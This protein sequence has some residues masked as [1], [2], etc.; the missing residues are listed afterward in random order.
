MKFHC[1]K[2]LLLRELT[3]AQEV[4]SN[5]S[6]ISI[7]SNVMLAVE[8][9]RLLLRATDTKTAYEAIIPVSV[10]QQGSIT[11]NSDKFIGSMK[12]LPD[13]LVSFELLPDGRFLIKPEKKS[14]TYYLRTM[15]PANYPWGQW[16]SEGIRFSIG[17]SELLDMINQTIFA[18][19]DDDARFFMT[20]VLFDYQHNVL[21]LVAT[22]GRRLS[23]ARK[24][25]TEERSFAVI[26]PTKPLLLLRKLALGQGTV[27]VLIAESSV[28]FN[29]DN[30][31]IFSNFIDGQFPN[32][33]RVIPE[34]Q[35]FT[36]RVNRD[37]FIDAIRRVSLL[38]DQKSQ[39]ILLEFKGDKAIISSEESELGLAKEE[40]DI[41]FN[42][43]ESLIAMNFQYLLDPL[44]VFPDPD[45]FFLFSDTKRAVTLRPSPDKN[46]F[47]IIMPMQIAE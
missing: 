20:G 35:S 27:E 36:V 33:Q 30:Q 46:F 4:I 32:Y 28:M 34:S 43:P 17:Q 45:V 44:R 23:L 19:S 14:I 9:G 1:D 26:V 13:G 24:E 5:R 21:K 22:D 3:N 12:N 38:A 15:S 39:R 7:L 6:T 29:L 31:R 41:E 37:D 47:H 10:D 2:G 8:D 16:S 42:G 25:M 40:I 11:V 18:V